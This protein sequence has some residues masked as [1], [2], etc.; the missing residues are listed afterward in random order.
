M[1]VE[2]ELSDVIHRFPG[3]DDQEMVEEDHDLMLS[4][5]LARGIVFSREGYTTINRGSKYEASGE[6]TALF[7][8]TN[9]VFAWG[10]ADAQDLPHEEIPKL[11]MHYHQSGADGVIAWA[12]YKNNMQPQKAVKI[13]MVKA[14]TW[15]ESLEA[16]PPNYDSRPKD[17]A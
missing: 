2:Y 13:D 8:N 6:G 3:P 10:C 14:G 17:P 12:C 9:D 4:I 11:F 7:V 1:K 16:L 15:N 5:L